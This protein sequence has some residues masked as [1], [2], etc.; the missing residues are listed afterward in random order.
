MV[1][2]QE[3]LCIIYSYIIFL[4]A[5]EHKARIFWQPVYSSQL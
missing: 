4:Y 2:V 3:S 5:T 1:V